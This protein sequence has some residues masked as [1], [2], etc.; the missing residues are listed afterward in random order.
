MTNGEAGERRGEERLTFS[1]QVDERKKPEHL[2]F[3]GEAAVC[4]LSF[5]PTGPFSGLVQIRG[6]Q[7]LIIFV[8]ADV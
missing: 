5:A 6:S 1:F 8:L 4:A 7:E 3:L 2:C